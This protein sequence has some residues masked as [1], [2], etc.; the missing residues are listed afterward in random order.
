[1]VSLSPCFAISIHSTAR[2]ETSSI[3]AGSMS[4]Y[5]LNPLHREGGDID[6]VNPDGDYEPF[7]STPPRGWRLLKSV[8]FDDLY[9]FQSTPP[10]GW[11]QVVPRDTGALQGISIHSTARVETFFAGSCFAAR[12]ISIH[13]TARVETLAFPKI[14]NLYQDFNPLHREGGDI[15]FQNSFYVKRHFNP[16]HREGGDLLV[17]LLHDGHHLFQS[18]P[19]RGWRRQ[20]AI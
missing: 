11:R 9:E 8:I 6:R 19:P 2:V 18:T 15:R 1:M 13:S 7:Q 16:L 17:L 14:F 4:L 12:S 5:Y 10:R 20:L 3:L